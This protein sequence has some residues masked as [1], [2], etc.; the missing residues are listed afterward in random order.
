M[1]STAPGLAGVVL[2][3]GYS[4][5]MGAFKPLLPLPGGRVVER[6]LDGLAA[7]GIMEVVV[8]TGHRAE[9]IEAALAGRACRL[10]R[11]PG[12]DQGMFS[13]VRA[14]VDA[15]SGAGAVMLWPVDVPLVRTATVAALVA[16]WAADARPGRVL[17]P[18]FRGRPGHPPIIGAGH[19][20]G[21]LNWSGERG[22]RGY[23]DA[24]GG[25]ERLAVADEG[26]LLDL[27]TP[28]EYE[29]ARRRLADR[30]ARDL[31]TSEESLAL[32]ELHAPAERLERLR[33]HAREVGRLAL[34]L[35]RALAAAGVA[36]DE[37]ALMAAALLHDVAKGRPEHW[38]RGAEIVAAAGFPE[39]S[40]A[41]ARHG[42]LGAGETD[43]LT[44]CVYLAD[45]CVLGAEHVALGARFD[46]AAHKYAGDAGALA[47]VAARRAEAEEAAKRF[48]ELA[49][50]DLESAADRPAEGEDGLLEGFA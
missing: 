3:A 4:S 7:A 32:Y 2:A 40:E 44:L 31:P 5:R 23:L 47:G 43:A 11:N 19:F 14:G 21:I 33:A 18:A 1:A 12:F 37:P 30:E 48:G 25:E 10:V 36:V 15:L 39:L 35:G 41:V 49:G 16:A 22:L 26:V 38:R 6:C 9:E 29:A 46:A 34:R 8:V 24:A 27:D 42:R 45:K 17:V 28:Q 20:A 50:I 13:S